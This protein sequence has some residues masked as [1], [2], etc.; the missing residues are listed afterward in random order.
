MI[1]ES[2]T[3]TFDDYDT[4]SFV[5]TTK[6][7]KTLEKR[8]EFKDKLISTFKVEEDKPQVI[9]IG[10]S[11]SLI[12]SILEVDSKCHKVDIN[13]QIKDIHLKKMLEAEKAEFEIFN[14]SD[15]YILG[16]L[17]DCSCIHKVK[18]VQAW[19]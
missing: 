11:K 2:T 19:A 15:E 10:N 8:I 4:Q 17:I 1:I 3:K 18:C 9:K 6:L 7:L 5:T 13:A 12:D 16:G 14:I